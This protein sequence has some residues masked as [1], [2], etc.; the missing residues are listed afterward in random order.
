MKKLGLLAGLA[1]LLLCIAAWRFPFLWLPSPYLRFT[2]RDANY[3]SEFSRACDSVL[4]SHPVT[5][6]DFVRLTSHIT[7]P[8]RLKLSGHDTSLPKIIARLDP[9]DLLVGSNSVSI[10]VPPERMGGFWVMWSSDE[11][12]TNQWKLE[13]GA[14]GIHNIVYRETKQ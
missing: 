3:Y 13:V 1:A 7:L 4:R 12:N 5:S 2:H 14:E 9:T 11:K 8:S 10:T 6:N